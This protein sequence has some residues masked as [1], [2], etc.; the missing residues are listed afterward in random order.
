MKKPR[1][2]DLLLAGGTVLAYFLLLTLIAFL[3]ACGGGS[4]P[5]EPSPPAV[6]GNY[7]G[8]ADVFIDGAYIT[9]LPM[10]ANVTQNGQNV[11]IS[12]RL[13]QFPLNPLEG[14]L[15]S[16]GFFTPISGGSPDRGVDPDC[17]RFS[18]TGARISFVGNTLNYSE[19]MNT[20][21]CG[22]IRIAAV[23]TR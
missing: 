12:A 1:R 4:G 19:T 22:E 8:P 21:F 11:T 18:S 13:D 6:A 3:P 5:S 16:N 15:S 7:A 9:T 23:L 20:S 10:T 2:N 14:T 17:G